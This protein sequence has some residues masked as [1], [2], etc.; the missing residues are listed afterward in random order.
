MAA[1]VVVT[2]RVPTHRLGL[3]ASLF[4]GSRIDE[5][6]GEVIVAER[7]AAAPEIARERVLRRV[8]ERLS[9]AGFRSSD[10]TLEDRTT[11]TS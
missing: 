6:R 9:A 2:I 8:E 7:S 5:A 3:V 4:L 1:R 11:T 10:Y